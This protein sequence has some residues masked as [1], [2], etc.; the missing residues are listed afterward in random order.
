MPIHRLQKWL[1]KLE[2]PY[3]LFTEGPVGK[4]HDDYPVLARIFMVK[5]D[6]TRVLA[7]LPFSKQLNIELLK[8][9][10]QARHAEL[11]SDAQMHESLATSAN[12]DDLDVELYADRSL[13]FQDQ[14]AFYLAHTKQTVVL[15][16]TDYIKL[17]KP[18]FCDLAENTHQIPPN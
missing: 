3:K 16:M 18:I 15:S 14:I 12:D 6:N 10:A 5:L 2:H 8:E 9:T 11:L 7:V 13:S 17:A 4:D 1:K